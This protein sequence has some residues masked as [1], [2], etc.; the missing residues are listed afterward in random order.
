MLQVL[1]DEGEDLA[2][3]RAIEEPVELVEGVGEVGSLLQSLRS[4]PLDFLCPGS[5]YCMVLCLQFR[6]GGVTLHSSDRFITINSFSLCILNMLN[7]IL[8]SGGL[9]SCADKCDGICCEPPCLQG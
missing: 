2:N 8:F 7:F 1:L 5:L 9:C 4:P 6:G 3:N